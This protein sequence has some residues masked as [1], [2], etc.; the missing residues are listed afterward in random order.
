MH[1][2]YAIEEI[3]KIIEKIQTHHNDWGENNAR[4]IH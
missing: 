4:N 2:I 1:A 3:Y